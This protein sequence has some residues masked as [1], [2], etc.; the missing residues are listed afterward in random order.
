MPL[1][2]AN[3]LAELRRQIATQAGSTSAAQ[4]ARRRAEVTL[5]MDEARLRDLAAERQRTTLRDAELTER[6]AQLTAKLNIATKADAAAAAS[7]DA[8]YA[9][10]AEERANAT[11]SET[12][13][14]TA[15]ETL[16]EHETRSRTARRVRKR[17][18]T[19]LLLD[20]E[21]RGPPGGVLRRD[22]R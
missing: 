21:P 14:A 22:R 11:A 4:E 3:A 2:C 20:Q 16:R 17:L 5:A 6:R 9:G 1:S 15:R 8:A 12:R 18:E 10:G 19:R 13:A 7:L